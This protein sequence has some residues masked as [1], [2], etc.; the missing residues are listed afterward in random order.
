MMNGARNVVYFAQ[1][2]IRNI[3]PTQVGDARELKY[4]NKQI[5]RVGV[6]EADYHF[7]HILRTMASSNISICASKVRRF[8]WRWPAAAMMSVVERRGVVSR[9]LAFPPIPITYLCIYHI[10][11]T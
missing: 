2:V 7:P 6:R 8:F 11:P 1:D 5:A 3:P 4:D 9:K 10:V